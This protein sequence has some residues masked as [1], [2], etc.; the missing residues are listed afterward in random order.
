M[1]LLTPNCWATTAFG[2]PSARA[3]AIV[4]RNANA[5]NDLLQFLAFCRFGVDGLPPRGSEYSIRDGRNAGYAAMTID[6]RL[7]A[8]SG[9]VLLS[10]D[11]GRVGGQ[12]GAAR[13][14]SAPRRRR[15]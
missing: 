2:N 13:G 3:N 14:S 9:V 7:A 15:G 5:C 8:I 4:D 11:A 6:R 10:P 12:P 1:A